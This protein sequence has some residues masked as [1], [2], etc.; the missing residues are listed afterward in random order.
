MA[1]FVREVAFLGEY[2]DDGEP[3]LSIKGVF[4]TNNEEHAKELRNNPFVTER[5]KP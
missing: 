5:E 1:V 2:T 3:K 4:G